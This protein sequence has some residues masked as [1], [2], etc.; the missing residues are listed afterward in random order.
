MKRERREDTYGTKLVE[1]LVLRVLRLE[2]V[3]EHCCWMLG[4]GEGCSSCSS[5]C[6]GREEL[7]EL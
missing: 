5:S 1:L 2:L 3:S 4:F 7:G 6:E